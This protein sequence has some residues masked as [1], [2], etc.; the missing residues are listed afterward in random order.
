MTF[1]NFPLASGSL[2]S[3]PLAGFWFGEG[4]SNMVDHVDWLFAAITSVGALVFLGLLVAWS[5]F[6]WKY[7]MR[8]GHAEEP[9]DSHNDKLELTWTIIPT[10][11]FGIIFYFGFTGFVDMRTPPD[12]A[13]EIHVTAAK[14]NWTFRYPNGLV[15]NEL[16]VPVNRPVKLIQ[17]SSDVLHSLYIPAFRIK[18][19]CVPGR[20]TYQWFEATKEGRY[21]LFCA[22]YC[23]TN[24]SNMYA[25]VY[26][27]SEEEFAEFLARDPYEGLDDVE[28]GQRLYI[29]RGCSS[30]HSIDG[31]AMAG[32]GPSFKGSFGTER[33]LQD[34][35]KVVMDENYIRESILQPA[36]KIH[37]GYEPRMPS[38]QGQIDDDGLRRLIEY[39]KSLR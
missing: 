39:I 18:M 8:P 19:D 38:F 9:S 32:G 20:Y 31:T 17:E 30:C 23:G 5:W 7:R 25:P 3:S 35:S 26:V 22:E 24:H 29:A 28:A 12:D 21:D 6:S 11:I 13:Y 33:P 2:P 34:G 15:V 14:W 10:I 37:Q 27:E 1:N 36:A 4:A 16:H